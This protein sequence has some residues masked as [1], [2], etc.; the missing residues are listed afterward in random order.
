M[1]KVRIPVK[2]PCK[3]W[4]ATKQYASNQMSRKTRR[5]RDILTT[6]SIISLACLGQFRR[7]FQTLL[8]MYPARK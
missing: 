6:V 5:T 8:C 2:G 4:D 7:N 3:I 1:T